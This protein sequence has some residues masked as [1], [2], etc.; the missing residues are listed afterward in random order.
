[1]SLGKVCLLSSNYVMSFKRKL[2]NKHWNKHLFTIKK[3]S[4]LCECSRVLAYAYEED[5]T[6][7][8]SQKTKN[9][10]I[11][12]QEILEQWKV[13]YTFQSIFSGE[14]IC[15]ESIVQFTFRADLLKK[16]CM[17]LINVLEI[18]SNFCSIKSILFNF[19]LF[20]NAGTRSK[21]C[22]KN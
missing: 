22:S 16:N 3:I 5:K 2:I 13:P 19:E 12:H 4:V 15:K 18:K 6:S 7:K 14:M 10:I 20:I 21:P 9:K 1:M 17:C 11:R 8:R